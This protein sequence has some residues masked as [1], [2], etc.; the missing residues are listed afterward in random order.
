MI[1][2]HFHSLDA[3]RFFSFFLVF[4]HHIPINENSFFS[5]FFKSGKI[6]VSFFFVVSGFLITYILIYEKMFHQQISIKFFFVRRI[7]RT[8]PLY[9]GMVLFAYLTPDILNL[10]KL[11]FSNEGYEPSWLISVSF[12]ENYKMMFTNRLP[13]VSPLAVMWSLCVEEHFYILWGV[14]LYFLPLRK[15]PILI[16]VSILLANLVRII[17]HNYDIEPL[18][19]FSNIDYFAYGAI[20]A[21]I[22]M[23]KKEVLK[24]V[25]DFPLYLKYFVV[26]IGLICVFVLPNLRYTFQYVGSPTILGIV[27]SL[28]ILFTLTKSNYIC[29]NDKY[30]ISKLGVFTYGLYLYHTIVINLMLRIVENSDS[31]MKILIIG[32]GSLL[33]SIM[34]SILSY[35]LFEKKIL[36][37]KKYFNKY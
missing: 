4:L 5:F 32:V 22:Y 17:Y 29:F 9:Y 24:S 31:E 28:I 26:L 21:Y 36:I 19:V 20:P 37:L 11:P 35:Y 8:W 30:L 18:D 25:G 27:F 34:I 10:L 13:N 2:K 7:L 3:I 12:L 6:G 15:I 14:I 16:G 23:R 33:I 1:K